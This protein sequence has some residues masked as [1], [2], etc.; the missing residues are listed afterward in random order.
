[1]R[2]RFE[3]EVEQELVAIVGRKE[4]LDHAPGLRTDAD[5]HGNNPGDAEQAMAQQRLEGAPVDTEAEI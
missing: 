3:I 4:F 5:R 1:M 2:A